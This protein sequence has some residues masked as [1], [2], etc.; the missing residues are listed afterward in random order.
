M[1]EEGPTQVEGMDVGKMAIT[2]DKEMDK[3]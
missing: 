3:L 2:G 1:E